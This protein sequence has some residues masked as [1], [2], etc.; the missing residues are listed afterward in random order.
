MTG[1]TDAD[2]DADLDAAAL[3]RAWI[4]HDR[5][6]CDA[7]IAGAGPGDLLSAVTDLAAKVLLTLTRDE[8][9]ACSLLDTWQRR[10]ITTEGTGQ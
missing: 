5:P 1:R 3:V 8:A 7:I 2:L 9:R 4:T 10:L 6:A